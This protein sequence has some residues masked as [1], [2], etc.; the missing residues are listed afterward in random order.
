MHEELR[1]VTVVQ[2]HLQSLT[3]ILDESACVCDFLLVISSSLV[4]KMQKVTTLFLI[5]DKK[6]VLWQEEP[7]DAAVNFDT[8]RIL[9]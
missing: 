3:S 4:L 2:G 6:V 7:R 1:C 5:H 9:Q 8:Y